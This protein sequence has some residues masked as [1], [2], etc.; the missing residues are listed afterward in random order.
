MTAAAS[1]AEPAVANAKIE[2]G[3]SDAKVGA[4]T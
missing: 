3:Q 4:S 2:K 1:D